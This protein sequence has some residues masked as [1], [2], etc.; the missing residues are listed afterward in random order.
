MR[1]SLEQ[2]IA[3]WRLGDSYAVPASMK[4]AAGAKPG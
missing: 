3:P 1:E 4:I 2:R